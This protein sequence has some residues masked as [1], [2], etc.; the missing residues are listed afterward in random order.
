ML[1]E[2]DQSDG[3]GESCVIEL[4]DRNTIRSIE[5]AWAKHQ[6]SYEKIELMLSAGDER[7]KQRGIRLTVVS[8]QAPEAQRIADEM[9]RRRTH[10]K[11]IPKSKA[12]SDGS[13]DN[14][15]DVAFLNFGVGDF[16]G[17]WI[18]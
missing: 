5:H 15:S 17:G 6:I 13:E 2:S 12:V 4:L 16:D 9:I 1:S 8:T 3:S 11:S 14:G 7:L 10:L 18:D